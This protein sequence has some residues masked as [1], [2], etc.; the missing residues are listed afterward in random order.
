MVLGG[1]LGSLAFRGEPGSG[2]GESGI[3][4]RISKLP[5]VGT[6]DFSLGGLVGGQIG[7]SSGEEFVHRPQRAASQ[8]GLDRRLTDMPVASPEKADGAVDR[9]DG[10]SAGFKQQRLKQS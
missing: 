8:H 9:I 7:R 10:A 6:G 4:I 3:G 5:H 1:F 2:V